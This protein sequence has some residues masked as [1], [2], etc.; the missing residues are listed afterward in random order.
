MHRGCVRLYLDG[1][2][3]CLFCEQELEDFYRLQEMKPNG[4]VHRKEP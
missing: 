3:P 1:E 4:Y 2:A